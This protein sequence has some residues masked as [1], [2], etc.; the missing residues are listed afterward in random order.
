M[1]VILSKKKNA[2][3]IAQNAIAL[4]TSRNILRRKDDKQRNHTTDSPVLHFI[5]NAQ[6]NKMKIGRWGETKTKLYGYDLETGYRE[7]N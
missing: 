5:I 1:T 7:L 2:I 4:N 3:K 6:R